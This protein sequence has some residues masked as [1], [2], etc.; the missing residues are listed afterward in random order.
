LDEAM[1]ALRYSP[2][3][4]PQPGE[5]RHQYIE[6]AKTPRRRINDTLFN[7][8]RWPAFVYS[9]FVLG[10]ALLVYLLY[11]WWLGD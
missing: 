10:F 8:I 6:P 4:P 11:R 5:R 2:P 7:R 3:E 1:S 9:W